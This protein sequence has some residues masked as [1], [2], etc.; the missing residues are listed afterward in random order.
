MDGCGHISSSHSALPAFSLHTGTPQE[1]LEGAAVCAAVGTGL[2]PLLRPH[3][4]DWESPGQTVKLGLRKWNCRVIKSVSH[5]LTVIKIARSF[6]LPSLSR[7]VK[8]KIAW[9]S[10]VAV[11]ES[12]SLT[13][14]CWR[15]ESWSD[16]SL[17]RSDP[18]PALCHPSGG[19][20]P[21]RR[22][23]SARMSGVVSG[24]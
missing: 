4:G 3:Q 14:Q 10:N 11:Y 17:S 16:S 1:E 24:R 15:P 13:G 18:L 9:T 21:R 7:P 5:E 22:L 19:R 6:L 20:Q 23:L 8:K 12:C 2:P